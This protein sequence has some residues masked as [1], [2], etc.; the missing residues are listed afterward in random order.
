MVLKIIQHYSLITTMWALSRIATNYET[1]NTIFVGKQIL[2][3]AH[4]Y[5]HGLTNFLIYFDILS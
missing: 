5:I 3:I 1:I 2:L 4:T